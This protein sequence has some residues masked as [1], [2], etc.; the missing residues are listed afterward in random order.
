MSEETSSPTSPG[1]PEAEAPGI[2]PLHRPARLYPE[3]VPTEA[4]VIAAP[5][6]IP[7]KDR[8]GWVQILFPLVGSLGMVAFALAYKN[9][10]FL[11][12]AG[13]IAILTTSVWIAMRV[14]QRRSA[15]RQRRDNAVRYREYLEE[16]REHLQEITARHRRALQ[17]VHPDTR[18]IWS[19]ATTRRNLW[20]RRLDDDDFMRLRIGLGPVALATPVSLE[21]R[22]DPLVQYEPELLAEAQEIVESFRSLRLAPVTVQTRSVGSL[23]IVGDLEAGRALARAMVCEMAAF[24]A[25]QDL[26]LVAWFAPEEEPSWAWMKW[27]PHARE[28]ALAGADEGRAVTL[29]VDASD[30]DVLLGEILRPRLAHLERARE[31]GPLSQEVSFQQVAVII[32]DYDPGS[33]IGRLPTLDELLIRAREIG[34]F[35]LTLVSDPDRVPSSI[36][37]RAELAQGGWLSYTESAPEGRREQAI[38]ADAAEVRLC[39]AVAR[40]TAPLRLRARTG[41]TTTV[42]SEGLLDLLGV[43]DP[44]GFDPDEAWSTGPGR[45][46]LRTPIG[47]ADDGSAAFLDLKESAEGGMGPHGLLVGATGSG[48]SELLRTLVTGLA[49]THSP[50]DL[51]FVLVDYKGGATFAELETLPQV[52]GTIT[53]LE[54]DLTLV[55]RMREALFG[56]LERRQRLLQDAGHFDRVREYQAHRREHPEEEMPPL[57]SLLLVVDEFGELLTTRPDFLDL[58]VSVGRTGRSLGIHLLLA[59][60][61]LDEGRITSLQSHLRYRICLRTFS[62]EESMAALGTRQA[63]ELPPLPGLGYLKVDRTV[64]RFKAALATRA[65]REHRQFAEAP[66]PVV[67]SFVAGGPVQEVAVVG[68]GAGASEAEP[69]PQPRGRTEMQVI[70]ESLA[71][72]AGEARRVRAVWLPPLPEALSLDAVLPDSPSDHMPGSPGWLRV[73][74]GLRDSPRDQAQS[75]FSVDFTGTGGHLAVVGAP[76]TGKSLMLSTIV[77]SV[78]LT[79]DPGDVQIYVLD[80]GGGGLYSLSGLPHVGAVYGRG[81]GE[82]AR[83]LV[84]EM[85]AIVDDRVAAFRQHRVEGM[86]AYHRARHQGHLTGSRHGEV[87]L[88]VDNWAQFVQDFPEL[89]PEVLELAATGLHYGVHLI[90]ASNRWND[91]RLALR[92][93]MGGRLELRLNDPL[94]SEID[95][96]AARALPDRTPGR[97]LRAG[98]EQV[99]VAL[100]RVDGQA[101]PGGLAVGIEGVVAAAAGRWRRSTPAAPVRMLPARVTPTDLPDPT[102]DPEPGVA[103]GIEEFSLGP[104]HVDLFDADPHFLV[105]GDGECGK[106]TLMRAWISGLAAKYPPDRVRIAVL[107]YRRML[108]EWTPESHLY[109]YTCTPEMAQDLA[110]RLA[111][112]L[113]GRL[114]SPGHSAEDLRRRRWWSGPEIALFVDDYDLVAGPSGS[115]LSGLVELLAQGRDVGFH[116]VLARRVGGTARSAFEPFLQRIRE[117]STPGLVMSGDP[118]EGPIIGE[119]KAHPLPP[120]RGYFVRR[121]RT[122]LVQTA[123]VDTE[124]SQAAEEPGRDRVQRGAW[125]PAS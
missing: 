56:E 59:T 51:A 85:Q 87:F 69:P 97:G 92:D 80:F 45:D 21:Q 90:L 49:V 68:A 47:V 55:D 3:P 30:L 107:D 96:H 83:R 123:F 78:A 89:E 9:I 24:H 109:G 88:V 91:F 52:A 100:P 75:P 114:P 37:A 12:V 17:R 121:R 63:F 11:A 61:R 39:E 112:E 74:V 53:N 110:S 101:D 54:R 35:V 25:P 95:R 103:V 66:A 33:A 62:P 86:P 120:G 60:Q 22:T 4:V 58:F 48:K 38:A 10:L 98:G 71:L 94:D 70:I 113:Q 34:V 15:K 65:Y 40:A 6:P 124:P 79:H 111:T 76:R 119:Q 42:E 18:D 102:S 64:E 16:N 36:G 50:E 23:A 20:E 28:S 108:L 43:P 104:V 117:L 29:A 105:F 77:A 67:R 1:H 41:R 57:P 99:Q 14:Q 8:G 116:V 7:S 5:P 82:E 73:P 93:N 115:P 72:G 31:A 2:V 27:L 26:R 125:R 19:L 44:K 106:T 118:T 32:D 46:L 84:R 81:D 122:T 13:S